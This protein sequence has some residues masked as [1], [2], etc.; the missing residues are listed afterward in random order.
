MVINIMEP[1]ESK[2]LNQKSGKKVNKENKK[3]KSFLVGLL[4]K[5]LICFILVII[6]LIVMKVNPKFK[7]FVKEKVFNNNISFAY[8]NNIYEKYFG[9]LLPKIEDGEIEEVFNEKLEYKNYN[10]YYDGY[11]LEVSNNYLV[12]IIKDGV[13]VF[14]GEIDNYG[15]VV[16]IEGIDGVDI[17]YGNIN[18]PS[19]S[20]YDYVTAG[21]YLGEAKGNFLYLVFEKEEKYLKY[22][23]YMY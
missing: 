9:A 19:V 3:K 5:I 2:F 13:V 17:W 10:I 23:D 6:C 15:N 21:N 20:L 22:E 8:L 14:S 18:N 7:T 11:K 1:T 16:I 12:P 4:N